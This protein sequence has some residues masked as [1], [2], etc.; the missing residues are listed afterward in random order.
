MKQ[1]GQEVIIDGRRYIYLGPGLLGEG[2]PRYDGGCDLEDVE[3]DHVLVTQRAEGTWE[4]VG[5]EGDI[6]E[7]TWL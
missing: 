5:Y 2:R 1:P 6:E 7:E 4:L 3:Y